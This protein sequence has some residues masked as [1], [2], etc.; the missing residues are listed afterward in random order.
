MATV[1]CG[2]CQIYNANTC[3]GK[4]NTLKIQDLALHFAADIK[5]LFRPERSLHMTYYGVERVDTL[6]D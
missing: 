2:N 3:R 1:Y 4:L 5:A 6:I